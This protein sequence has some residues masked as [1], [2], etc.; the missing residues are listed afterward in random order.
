MRYKIIVWTEGAKE[1]IELLASAMWRVEHLVS[2]L[3]WIPDVT[4][5]KVIKL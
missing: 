5:I 2:E 1:A 4:T 3:L